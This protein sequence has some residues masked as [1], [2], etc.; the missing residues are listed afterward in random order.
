MAYIP[1]PKTKVVQG[2]IP[3]EGVPPVPTNPYME[4]DLNSISLAYAMSED[5]MQEMVAEPNLAVRRI[6]DTYNETR[7]IIKKNG[8]HHIKRSQQ[9]RAW[10]ATRASMTELFDLSLTDQYV[11]QA[12]DL[13]FAIQAYDEEQAERNERAA[14]HRQTIE[15][16]VEL[17][18]ISGEAIDI[19]AADVFQTVLEDKQRELVMADYIAKSQKEA[20][21]EGWFADTIDGLLYLVP[22]ADGLANYRMTDNAIAPF[23]FGDAVEDIARQ[24]GNMSPDDL[25][26]YLE[27]NYDNVFNKTGIIFDNPDKAAEY[28]QDILY[29][30]DQT[31]NDKNFWS[32]FGTAFALGSTVS[33]A[34]WA[35][36]GAK[37][38]NA[39]RILNKELNEAETINKAKAADAVDEVQVRTAETEEV[40]EAQAKVRKEREALDEEV[41]KIKEQIKNVSGKKAE[42]K[43]GKAELDKLKAKEAE[44]QQKLETAQ[45][46]AKKRTFNIA[47]Q[48]KGLN[49]AEKE[50]VE[51]YPLLD[52]STRALFKYSMEGDMRVRLKIAKNKVKEKKKLNEADRNILKAE[53]LVKGITGKANFGGVAKVKNLTD[54][55]L[56]VFKEA[57]ALDKEIQTLSKQLEEVAKVRKAYVCPV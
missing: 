38:V 56:Y 30:D 17:R 18:D 49:K 43:E 40:A 11:D 2:Y 15:R 29:Y 42:T 4:K 33:I 52:S 16:M 48:V 54:P 22:F 46:E 36:V 13:A 21:D 9:L 8:D 27:D 44:L 45:K 26:N 23:L 6:A 10:E 1:Q 24:V 25:A 7:E 31:K 19:R 32:L 51:A 35:G 55:K 57:V 37:Q 12:A 50:F 3:P 53:E 47:Q 14:T 20:S 39:N 5:F 41:N 28:W 34:K